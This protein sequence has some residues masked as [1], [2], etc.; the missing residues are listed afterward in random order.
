VRYLRRPP[1]SRD[2]PVKRWLFLLCLIPNLLSAQIWIGDTS[3]VREQRVSRGLFY[4]DTVESIGWMRYDRSK[5]WIE[6]VKPPLEYMDWW[7]KTALCQGLSTSQKDYRR[8]RWFLIN[9][10][11]FGGQGPYQ[12]GFWGYFVQDSMAIYIARPHRN[13]KALIQHEV[14]HFLMFLNGEPIGHPKSRFG[15]F[16]CNFRYVE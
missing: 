14:T 2:A 6:Q 1:C 7:F 10:E 5:P 3:F 12:I 16:G 4:V 15:S 11:T 13:N 9:R 8:V